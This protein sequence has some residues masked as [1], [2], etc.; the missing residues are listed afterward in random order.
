MSNHPIKKL[1]LQRE[2]LRTL[3]SDELAG[4]HGG[5]DTGSLTPGFAALAQGIRD[6]VYRPDKDRPQYN[7]T[8]YRGGGRVVPV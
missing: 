8:V 5:K 2:T 4:I 1:S 7:D 6:T 3:C